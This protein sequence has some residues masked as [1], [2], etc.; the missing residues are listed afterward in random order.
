MKNS[1]T[2]TKPDTPEKLIF[3]S[4]STAMLDDQQ[5]NSDTPKMIIITSVLDDFDDGLDASYRCWT[6]QMKTGP[7]QRA[8]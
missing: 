5:Q 4:V 1:Q 7:L 2:Q 8:Y 3:S 6:G